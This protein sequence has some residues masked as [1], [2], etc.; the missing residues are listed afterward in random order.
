MIFTLDGKKY[1]LQGIDSGP[2]K[3]A[4]FQHLAIDAE[5]KSKIPISVQPLIKEFQN[6]F[7]EPMSL[8]PFR[9]HFHSIPLIPNASPPNI[10]P[11]RY[12]HSQKTEIE[13]QVKELLSA[14]FI[15]PST[16]PFSSPILLVK[17]KYQTWILRSVN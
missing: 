2:Q 6:V 5:L 16:S 10:R 1:K 8:P 15:Q 17:K 4:E 7:E 13:K 12:P 3:S 14:G 9:T 11:Y